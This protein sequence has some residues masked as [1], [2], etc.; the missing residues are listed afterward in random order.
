MI[1][2]FILHLLSQNIVVF[3]YIDHLS[4]IMHT[5]QSDLSTVE[6]PAGILQAA[7]VSWKVF[8]LYYSFTAHTFRFPFRK[9]LNMRIHYTESCFFNESVH[10]RPARALGGKAVC[11]LY[12]ECYCALVLS[13]LASLVIVSSVQCFDVS[14]I[15][16]KSLV[17]YS[18][19]LHQI[20]TLY[21]KD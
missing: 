9:Y 11:L 1:Y 3:F 7:N 16:R 6:I 19:P 5:N 15:R 4:T 12:L 10:Y 14:S 2:C 8:C 17:C 21:L 20:P 18:S 13:S